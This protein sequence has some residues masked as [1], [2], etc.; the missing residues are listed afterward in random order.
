MS[1]LR[2]KAKG[3]ICKVKEVFQRP[4]CEFAR[5]EESGGAAISEAFKLMN[6]DARKATELDGEHIITPA[7]KKP[8]L[9]DSVE[10]NLSI[11]PPP[12][13]E[14]QSVSLPS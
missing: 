7:T 10:M 5:R 11:T 3:F 13:V 12:P 6:M 1:L 9:T 4:S 8:R 14:R 2:S